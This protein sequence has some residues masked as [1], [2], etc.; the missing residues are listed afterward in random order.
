[1]S[2][3]ATAGRRVRRIDG[4]DLL[5]ALGEF[6]DRLEARRE[7]INQINV[8]PVADAD[9][10]SNLFHTMTALLEAVS[11][12][13]SLHE[14]ARSVGD[15]ALLA[16][17]G[18]SGLILTQALAGLCAALPSRDDAGG[19]ELA[20]ALVAAGTYAY[21]SVG[22]PIEGT[23]LTAA[24]MAG[25]AATAAAERGGDALTVAGAAR[26]GAWTA[27]AR[28]PDELPVLAE[29]GVVDGGAV[30]YGLLLDSLWVSLDGEEAP[31]RSI[32]DGPAGRPEAVPRDRYEVIA[33]VVDVSAP[34]A[35]R[36]NLTG[37]GS[38]VAV[39]TRGGLARV[40]CHVADPV[41]ALEV[42]AAAG[43]IRQVEVTDLHNQIGRR[44][45]PMSL[46]VAGNP[47]EAT[48][49]C[50]AGADRLIIP[51]DAARVVQSVEGW[52]AAR[53][54]I[55]AVG[56]AAVSVAG[57]TGLGADGVEIVAVATATEAAAAVEGAQG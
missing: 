52:G 18:A 34:R 21:S 19:A 25:E 33:T 31:E 39:G 3:S 46:V 20:Q 6:R 24:R 8:F 27:V 30:G 14:A 16:G 15:S 35:L 50:E 5:R 41:Q 40:H 56:D 1:M 36:E 49:L 44:R 28:S 2:D 51:V 45:E 47:A 17:R 54:R 7:H 22:D 57:I 23:M 55:V 11:E 53:V 48:A 29:E 4:N 32:P 42:M 37:V 43:S 9:T 10:G 13:R 12:S 38:S 26:D